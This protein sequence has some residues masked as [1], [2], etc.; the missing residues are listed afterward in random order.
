MKFQWKRILWIVLGLVAVGLI[1]VAMLPKAIPVETV[2]TRRGDLQV[3]VEAEG[4]TRVV[5]R[6]TV[7]APVTGRLSRVELDAGDSLA[8]GDLIATIAPPPLDLMQQSELSA[9]I[10]AAE[11]NVKAAA[12]AVDRVRVELAQ[13]ERERDRL[14]GLLAIGSIPAHDLELAEKGVESAKTEMEGAEARLRGATSDV[15]VVRSG[16]LALGGEGASRLVKITSPVAGR[17]LRVMERDARLVAAGTPIIG[18][19]DPSALEVVVDVL[20]SDAVA[21]PD[22]ASIEI[23]GWGG[24][25]T[26]HARVKYIE[27]S[28]FTKVSVLGIDE[29]RVNVVAELLDHPS[30]LGDGF[31]VDARII[32]WQGTNVLT[33]PTSALFRSGSDWSVFV[34]ADN[35]ARR[36]TVRLGHRGTF[37]VEIL[38]GL[39]DGDVVIE[40]PS[41]KIE[42]GVEVK[43]MQE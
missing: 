40:H 15:Q 35:R 26:L 10:D 6:F 42:E 17:V 29:Q 1:V 4:E 34:I 27:P 14:R 25:T 28:A 2:V 19:G 36:R 38:D 16:R 30:E 24:D 43:R 13:A 21:I 8:P 23:V 9:R 33:I 7:A 18:I 39:G 12:A 11:A 20:S 5:D 31:R 41:D 32:T 3:V 37:E 22:H